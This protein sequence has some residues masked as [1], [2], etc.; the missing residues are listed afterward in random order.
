MRQ[1]RKKPMRVDAEKIKQ[2][3]HA[4]AMTQEKLARLSNVDV[5]TVQR[6]EKGED[7]SLETVS[8][9][10]AALELP[11]LEIMMLHGD[12]ATS[13]ESESKGSPA[14]GDETSVTVL[15]MER[16]ADALLK[17]FARCFTCKIEIAAPMTDEMSSAVLKFSEQIEPYLPN[18]TP[19]R[20]RMLIDDEIHPEVQK[21]QA[22]LAAIAR[23]SDC[24]KQ[25]EVAGYALYTGCYAAYGRVPGWDE[26]TQCWSVS[27]RQEQEPILIA[28]LKIGRPSSERQTATI[29]PSTEWWA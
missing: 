20:S 5:R 19:P 13:V 11:Q 8:Q 4:L 15:R 22:Q 1:P 7:L 17:L 10:A 23:L 26:E 16:T 29:L 25:L 9:I 28:V 3:R 12:V 2:R 6:A 27:G 14:A 21:I 24:L 18:P